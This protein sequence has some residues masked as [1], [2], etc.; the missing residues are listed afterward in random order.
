MNSDVI[1]PPQLTTGRLL[2]LGLSSVIM[3]ISFIMS[4]FAP[5]PLALAIILYGRLKGFL[6]GLMGLVL[7]FV[8]AVLV[9]QDLTLFGFYVCVFVFAIA[10]SEIVTRGISP[11]KG[12]VSFGLLFI[13]L[14][15][16][17]S[18][19][20]IKSQDLTVEQF[21]VQQIEKSSD[22]L[23]EQKA[24]IEKS[25]DKDTIEALQL[26][27]NPKLLAKELIAALPSYFFIGVFLMLWFNMFIVLK[28]RRL[29]LSGHDY[30]YSER[31]LLNFKV[32]F[33]FV[34]VLVLALVMAVWGEDLGF[35][36]F[37][38]LGFT[39]IKC[40]GIFYFF[41]GF[42]VF[43]DLLNFLGVAGFFRSLIVMV[44]IFLANYMIAAAGLFDNWFDFRKYFVKRNTEE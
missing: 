35:A 15:S 44:V 23:A 25:T 28:G 34:F 19:Y 7:S 41:Q 11:I 42:G 6:T 17:I 5:F 20:A 30:P 3:C 37:E 33:P 32:P 38:S 9:Y 12:M 1:Q 40:L 2:F 31:N 29:L 24:I 8:F 27:E 13:A 16:A 18:G 10:I 14:I 43:S 21:V 26:L 22:K 36:S 39:I 4:V